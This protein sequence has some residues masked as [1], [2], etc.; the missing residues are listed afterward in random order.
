MSD[1]KGNDE[2]VTIELEKNDQ[3]IVLGVSVVGC[4]VLFFFLPRLAS[5]ALTALPW[6]PWEGPLKLAVTAEQTLTGWG[7][8]ILGACSGLGLGLV[9]LHGEPVVTISES[10]QRWLG[11][12]AQ[13]G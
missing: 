7:M 6:V 4:A 13:L 11:K 5:W 2:P 10:E 1:L 9:I 3:L 12:S 8:G